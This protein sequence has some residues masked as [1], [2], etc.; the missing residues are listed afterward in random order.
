M[1]I[2]EVQA[3]IAALKQQMTELAQQFEL[4]TGC[5]IHSIPVRPATPTTAVEVDIKVQIP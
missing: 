4:S 2:A 5:K 1:T 3:A